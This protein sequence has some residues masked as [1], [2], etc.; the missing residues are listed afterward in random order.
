[1]NKQYKVIW[2]KVKNSYV[3]VSE[4]A[5]QHS[6]GG[7]THSK[8]GQKIG[9]A[10]AVMA[11]SVGAT[12]VVG[13]A[14]NTAGSGSGVAVG[15]G[16]SASDASGVAIGQGATV[17]VE[18]GVALGAGSVANVSRWSGVSAYTPSSTNVSGLDIT[19]PA[20][21]ALYYGAV[22]VGDTD[23]TGVATKSR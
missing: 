4:L 3:V 17:N 13:A 22:S 1:M 11:L 6:K 12:G 21:M 16:S 2:S 19:K 5:K 20:W 18:G 15:S 14:N 8:V 7:S 10:L 9:V 23:S